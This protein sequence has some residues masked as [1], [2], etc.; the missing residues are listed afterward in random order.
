MGL[1]S[2]LFGLPLAPVKGTVW[3][4]EQ[5]LQEAEKQ[6]YDPAVIRS[7]L[8]RVDELRESGEVTEEEAD[9]WEEELIARLLEGQRRTT[10]G[11]EHGGAG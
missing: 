3:V 11:G 4:A 8:D 6:Y 1:F 10:S 5:V 9:E 7:E 2:S